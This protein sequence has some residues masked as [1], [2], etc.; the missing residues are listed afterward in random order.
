MQNGN[1]LPAQCKGH[2]SGMVRSLAI[3]KHSQVGR[4]PVKWCRLEMAKELLLFQLFLL[5]DDV[6]FSTKSKLF[7]KK[8]FF[9]HSSV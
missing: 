4:I 8:C 6:T 1:G 7:L 5:R 3:P 2:L 9:S